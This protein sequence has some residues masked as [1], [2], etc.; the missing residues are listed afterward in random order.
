MSRKVKIGI[1]RD[2]FDKEGKPI[3][4]GPGLKLLEAMP[5]VEYRI[6][7]EYLVEATPEQIKD[8]DMVIVLKPKFNAKT[9]AGNDQ[10]LAIHR[11]GVGYDT[12]DV[13]AMTEAGVMLTITPEGVRRPMAVA[14]ITLIL[15]LSSN[16]FP[17]V[18]LLRSG[19]WDRS[20]FLGVGLV[21]KTLGSI[22]VGN[23]GHE[24]FKL[25]MPFGM[26]HIAYDPFITQDKVNDVNVRLVDMDTVLKESDFLNISCPLNDKTFHLIGEKE[27]RKMKKTAFIINT[28]RGPIIDEKALYKALTEGWIQ[29]AG[30]DVFEQEPTPPDNPLLKLENVIPTP[31]SLGWT[32]EI[33]INIWNQI[34]RQISQVIRGEIPE[35][36]VNKEVLNNPKFQ[37]KMKRF[38]ES[39]R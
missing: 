3:T 28:A 24:A 19:V 26:K 8:L 18:K 30:I 31:H 36:L 10:L 12:I 11:N 25:A 23:I 34:M 38:L 33:F 2:M 14:I 35:G 4:P 20:K 39:T 32:D 15:C 22:G 17:K 29:G 6:F 1:T 37:A 13:P 21:G 9:V 7:K 27:L 16:I 5:N